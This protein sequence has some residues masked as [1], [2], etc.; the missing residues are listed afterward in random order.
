M[1]I[2][3]YT[4]HDKEKVM[5]LVT[6]IL[7]KIFHEDSRKNFLLKEF[8]DKGY[9]LFLV[10]EIEKEGGNEIIGTVGLKP[11]SN[12]EEVKLKRLYLKEEYAGRGIAQRIL[13][14][15]IGFARAKEHKKIIFQ[16]Y[17]IMSKV[18]SFLRKN[19]FT[20][21]DGKDPEML[22]FEKKLSE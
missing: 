10:V 18:Q 21:H 14:Q 5:D 7:D 11:S 4:P 9:S 22:Y 13:D 1:K 6:P 20:E 15:C 8:D 2:R 19:G 16:A 12:N 3:L 17:P